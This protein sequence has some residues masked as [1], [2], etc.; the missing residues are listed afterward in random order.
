MHFYSQCNRDYSQ[1]KIAENIEAEI[2]QVVLDEA[3]DNF[4]H[5]LVHE[6]R[7]ETIAE[8]ES[9][10]ERIAAWVENFKR[11]NLPI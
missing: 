8:L 3:R 4:P 5:E 2:M 6:I 1:K 7:G 9:N 11:N 10:V